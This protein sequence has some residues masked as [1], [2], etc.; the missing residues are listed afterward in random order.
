MFAS[1]NSGVLND[2]S[3]VQ[4]NWKEETGTYY[5]RVVVKAVLDLIEIVN[6]WTVPN[7]IDYRK[8]EVK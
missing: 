8:G 2:N 6:D 3:I 1:I 7:I 5:G 4:F